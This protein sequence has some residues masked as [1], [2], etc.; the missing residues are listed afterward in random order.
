M[1]YF[2]YSLNFLLM[3]ILPLLLGLFLARRFG[4][5]WRFFIVGAVT[6]VLAQVFHIPLNAGLT[7]AFRQGLLPAPPAAWQTLF[8]AVVLGLTAGLTEE[9]ARYFVLKYALKDDR[10]WGGALMFG[11]G[12]GGGEAIMLG[13]LAALS[14]ISLVLMQN[15]AGLLSTLPPEQLAAA[16]AQLQ[17]YWSAPWYVSLLGAVE[18]VF[19]LILQ[20][21]L[22]VLV[23]QVFLRRQ[24]RWL[25]IAIGWHTLVNA[26]AVYSLP[27]W[28]P[29]V[30][31]GIVAVA[32]L[33]SLGIIYALRSPGEGEGG[34]VGE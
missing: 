14:F 28:G 20:M 2:T 11:A 33:I 9:L 13:V 27:T 24:L 16:Q 4:Q 5:P 10:S 25:V 26:V 17:A 8:N 12:H 15:N 3:I 18:R 32:G 1:L 19:A 31:E 22:A 29:L 7:L 23:M 21:S 6:F 30:T 34:R